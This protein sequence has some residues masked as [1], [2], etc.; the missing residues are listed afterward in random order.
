MR[1]SCL[2][3]NNVTSMQRG[4]Q[5][6]GVKENTD[7]SKENRSETISKAPLKRSAGSVCVR[8]AQGHQSSS[9][10]STVIGNPFPTCTPCL[11]NIMRCLSK[12]RSVIY[13]HVSLSVEGLLGI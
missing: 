1:D 2:L 6:L 8:V 4:R 9:K 13:K 5:R 11:E 7:N 10:I 3:Q 12:H